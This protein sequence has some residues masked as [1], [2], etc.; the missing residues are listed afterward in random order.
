MKALISK[1]L[2]INI[3]IDVDEVTL[4]MNRK[5]VTCFTYK[6]GDKIS[7]LFEYLE[8]QDGKLDNVLCEKLLT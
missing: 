3:D 7:Y 6:N 8:D 5:Y 2:N 4:E 1:R